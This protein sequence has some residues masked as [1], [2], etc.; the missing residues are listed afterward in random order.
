MSHT[1]FDTL[2]FAKE[3]EAAGIPAPHAEAF[4][5][6]QRDSLNEALDT[7]VATKNDVNEAKNEV[8]LEIN[9]VKFEIKDLK[10][11]VNLIKWM[12]GFLLAGS[13]SL[14]VKAFF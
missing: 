2:K 7:S 1:A 6:A 5:K 12:L 4:V 13:I 14:I 8:K 10:S 11:E 3:L 9:E